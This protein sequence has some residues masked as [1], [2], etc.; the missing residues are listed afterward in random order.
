M[1]HSILW[2]I[3]AVALLLASWIRFV[4]TWIGLMGSKV[5]TADFDERRTKLANK[6]KA[7]REKY[8]V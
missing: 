4:L 8:P 2:P 7:I 3:A 1:C 5:D 6:V